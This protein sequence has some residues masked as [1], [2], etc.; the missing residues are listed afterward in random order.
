[1][2][3]GTDIYGQPKLSAQALESLNL[4]DVIVSLEDEAQQNLPSSAKLKTSTVRQ[5]AVPLHSAP[6]T[7]KSC[8]EVCVCGHLRKEKNPFLIVKALDLLPASSRVRVSHFGR[9]LS[10]G[11]QRRA[12]KYSSDRQR[13]HWL[14]EREHWK[15]R[16][17]IGRSQL[18]VNSSLM[19]SSANSVVESLVLG[20]PVLVTD[21][22]GNV[23]VFGT[24]YPGIYRSNDP[25]ELSAMIL[26]FENDTQFRNQISKFCNRIAKQHT[27]DAERRSWKKVLQELF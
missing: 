17:L 20:T 10:P 12:E 14:G 19:E 22:P 6:Q 11:F 5:S 9:A 2:I 27:P 8:L 26:R 3:S 23:G 25:G 16:Q 24:D 13:Y 1:M 15:A 21:V 18:M 7:L 4:C